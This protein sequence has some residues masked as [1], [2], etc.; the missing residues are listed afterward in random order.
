MSHFIAHLNIFLVPL[1]GLALILIDYRSKRHADTMPRRLLTLA[2]CFTILSALCELSY[3]LSAEHEGALPYVV[4]WTVN[5]IFFM[6]QISAFGFMAL[7]LDYCTHG[8]RRR[9]KKLLIIAGA[10]WAANAVAVVV[11]LFTGFIFTIGDKAIDGIMQF[12]VYSRANMFWVEMAI[13]Y[14]F[15]VFTFVDTLISRKQM[16]KELFALTLIAVLP[17]AAGALLDV[18]IEG[19]RLVI[20]CFFVSL[21][22][23]YL[24]IVRN[25]T[26]IDGLTGIYNRRACD[27]RLSVIAKTRNKSYSFIMIDMDR[28]KEINDTFGHAQGDNALR[29]AAEILRA[30]VRRADFTARYGGDEF[31]I[32]AA[33]KDT[34]AVISRIMGSVDEFNA[35]KLRPYTLAMSCGGAVYQP[36]D[37]R[38]PAEFLT[39]ADGL[40]Y[41]RKLARKAE[42]R[43]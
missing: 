15:I 9:L 12:N 31:L 7:F 27:E 40:M 19:S 10:I 4:G 41:E 18:L 25:I 3:Y 17:T 37:A 39:Y 2:M 42:R 16:N 13:C 43:S 14:L 21:L 32:I 22:F 20:P 28:F 29:D 30:A 35:K 11:N 34:D 33:S 24:F 36:D 5:S 8:S 38:T 23:A 6:S 1:A 26:L